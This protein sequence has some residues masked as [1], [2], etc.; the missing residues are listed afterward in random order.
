VKRFVAHVASPGYGLPIQPCQ[1]FTTSGSRD[2]PVTGA[3][4]FQDGDP[5]IPEP[6]HDGMGPL[7]TMVCSVASRAQELKSLRGRESRDFDPAPGA[8][9]AE[10]GW[11][12]W[13]ESFRARGFDVTQKPQKGRIRFMRSNSNV[14]DESDTLQDSRDDSEWVAEA[15]QVLN[16]VLVYLPMNPALGG[17]TTE[18]G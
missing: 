16:R 4:L 17:C 1:Q 15:L 6:D 3:W 9:Q 11:W 12:H 7:G 5:A 8:N 18:L 2:A 13:L 10:A 14:L